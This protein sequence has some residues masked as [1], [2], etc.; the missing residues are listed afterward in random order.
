MEFGQITWWSWRGLENDCSY[1]ELAAKLLY[2]IVFVYH[3]N[4]IVALDNL[5][6]KH[7]VSP[8]LF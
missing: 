8:S 1:Y 2:H 3:V 7:I 5:H 6:N 4:G